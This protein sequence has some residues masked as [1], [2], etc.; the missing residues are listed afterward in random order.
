M[1]NIKE[2][3]KDIV[4]PFNAYEEAGDESAMHKSLLELGESLLTYMVGI[5]FG[6]YKR[7][8][9]VSEKLE[10]EFYKYSSRKPSFG[11]FLSFMRILSKEMDKTILSDKF[12][13]SKKYESASEFIFEFNLLK[14]VINDGANEVFSDKLDSL[15]KGRSAGQNGL[16]EFFDT[17]IMIRNTYAHPED[18]AGPKDNKRKWP[19]TEEYYEIINPHMHGALTEIIEDFEILKSYKPILAKSL[20]DQGKKGKFEVEIGIKGSELELKLSNEDLRFVSSDVRYLLD[21]DEKL[22]VK[23]YYSKIPQLNPVVAKK[24]IDNEKAKAMEPHMIEMINSKLTDDGKIDDMEYLILRDTAKT[25]SISI[26]N[27]FKLIQKSMNKLQ[28]KG[29]VGTPDNKGDIFVEVKDDNTKFNFNPWWLHYL[30]MVPKIDK[31]TVT[32]EQ[33]NEKKSEKQIKT[34]KNSK[35]NLP[36][37]KRLENAKKNLKNKKL[38]KSKQLKSITVQIQKKR[39]VRTK[40]KDSERKRELLINIEEMNAKSDEKRNEFDGQIIELIQT[41]E[42]IEKEKAEKTNEIDA[43]ISKLSIELEEYSKFTQWGMHKNLWQE[44]NQYVNHLLDVNLNSNNDYTDV[45]EESTMNWIN[46]QNQWQIGQLAYTY[47]AK[48]HRSESPLGIA[49]HV[50]FAI[51]QKFKWLPR[52]IDESLIHK[53]K[54][55]SSIIWTST[56]DQWANKIDIDGSI[57]KKRIEIFMEM[58]NDYENELLDLGANVRCIPSDADED[59]DGDKDGFFIPM[60]KYIDN[61]NKYLVTAIY[62]RIWPVDSFYIDGKVDLEA[63]SQYEKEMVTMLQLFTNSVVQ[64]N[65]F[66]L[67]N[68][69]NQETIEERFDQYNRLK[70]VMFK[71]FEK[72][73]PVGTL[74]RPNKEQDKSWREFAQNELGLSDY[75]YDLI[76]SNFRFGSGYAARK[77]LREQRDKFKPDSNEYKKLDKKIREL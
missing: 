46:S 62:S 18:K 59:F 60:Q 28:I 7:S 40:A 65:D 12:E 49:W 66:A 15:R 37:S 50:G 42:K 25:S 43:K 48:I 17:F 9:T 24:I 63:I 34:L 75:L 53:L 69:I 38:Q 21:P 57:G 70:D 5:M 64:L 11:V 30:S 56:D 35:K 76:S 47:W 31:K 44:I 19:L 77:Y 36:V 33:G 67:E 4:Q 14:Q 27:L 61:K 1:K 10:T 3:P 52:N 13:K 45:D 41:V 55:P 2:Y 16:M 8:G 54:K 71:E 26:E 32:N 58:L 20:D 68:G 6:E 39:A 23:F 51:S 29:S 22:F 72:G 73:F 74:F